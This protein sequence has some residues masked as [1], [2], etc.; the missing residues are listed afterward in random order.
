MNNI[1]LLLLQY[2]LFLLVSCNP[3]TGRN[4]IIENI[5][6]EIKSGNLRMAIQMS[7]SLKKYC[8]DDKQ[9]V[10]KADSLAQVAGR[11]GIDFSVTEE[12]FIGQ[13]EKRAGSFSKQD[14]ANWEKKGWLEGRLIDGKKM[15]FNRAASNLMLLKKFYEQKEEWLRDNMEDPNMIFRLKHTLEAY[16]ATD[17]QSNPTTPVKMGITY[18]ITVDPDAV[19]AGEVIR[20]WL[21]WPKE[22]YKRQQQ[23]ELLSVSSPQ[24]IISPDSAIHRSIYMEELSKKGIPTVFKVSYNYQSCAQY[25]DM[26]SIKIIPYNRTSDNY[27]KYTSEQLP[28]ICFT[29]N[30]KRLTDSITEKEDNPVYLVRKIYY[31][32]KDNIPWTGALEYSIIQ[33]IPEYVIQNRRGDCGMQ[34]FLFISML[35]YKGIP[36]RWQSGW[37][38]PPG[39]KNLHDWCEVYFEG[40][41]W[42]PVDISYDLQQTNITQVKEFYLS[43]IDSYRLIINDGISGPLHPAKQYMR[44]EPFD[45]QRGEVEWKGGNLYFNKW[46]YNMKIDYIGLK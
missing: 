35:R 25:F 46:S 11:I 18:T 6:G 17:N 29:E 22:S 43:G 7:D 42:I 20:C 14:I 34:T 33:N 44:S 13:I 38:L 23:V 4:Q 10:D 28:Q 31:W 8:T 30:V 45:F 5:I 32:F 16:K 3:P 2:F 21:P 15:Y 24:Y 40:T 36:V 19:P 39:D 9:L 26:T 41:G 1:K 27:K 37:M 12:Q